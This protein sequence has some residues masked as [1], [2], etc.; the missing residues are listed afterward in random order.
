MLIRWS[1]VVYEQLIALSGQSADKAFLSQLTYL[2]M[3]HD[4]RILKVDTV[5]AY[6]LGTKL[7]VEVHIA[8]PADMPL[9]VAHDIGESLEKNIEKLDEVELAFVHAD[10]EWAHTGEH[11]R[12]NL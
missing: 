2:A 8:L 1:L 5:L 11:D 9:R 10:F 3:V 4:D 6:Q 12:W 7:H